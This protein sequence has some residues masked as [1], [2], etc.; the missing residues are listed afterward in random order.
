MICCKGF[1]GLLTAERVA[2]HNFF[3]D[4]FLSKDLEVQLAIWIVVP[5]YLPPPG[6]PKRLKPV[7]PLLL[8]RC[9]EKGIEA[10]CCVNEGYQKQD[11]HILLWAT[12][13]W[14]SFP[15]F[16]SIFK[17]LLLTTNGLTNRSDR[18]NGLLTALSRSTTV[19]LLWTRAEEKE[20]TSVSQQGWQGC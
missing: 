4:T 20:I 12:Q 6:A 9:F 3:T 16:Q 13:F 7:K 18:E 11:C 17:P 10:E 5:A 2:K 19:V 1:S 8:K 14:R 15:V